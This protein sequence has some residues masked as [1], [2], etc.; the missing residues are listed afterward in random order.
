MKVHNFLCLFVLCNATV[1]VISWTRTN[2]HIVENGTHIEKNGTHLL[3]SMPSGRVEHHRISDFDSSHYSS[4]SHAQPSDAAASRATKRDS[5]ANGWVSSF[6]S[7]GTSYT[8]FLAQWTVPNAPI[9]TQTNIV[10][11]FN[12]FEGKTSDGGSGSDIL[13]PVLQYN[14]GVQGWT[15]AS[16]YGSGSYTESTPVAVKPGDTIT[17]VIS[18]DNGVWSV[19]GYVNGV[20]TT[21]LTIAQ[22]AFN[23]GVAQ[24]TAQW[25][26][27]V[28]NMPDC[29]YYPPNDFLSLTDLVLKDQGAIVSNP[30]FSAPTT[31][32]S[33]GCNAAGYLTTTPVASSTSSILTITWQSGA[34][35]IGS[36]KAIAAAGVDIAQGDIGT[37]SASSALACASACDNNNA[38]VGWVWDSQGKTTCWLKNQITTRTS[39]A[40]RVSGVKQGQKGIDR[41]SHDL[42]GYP[43]TLPSGST[44]S[45]CAAYCNG[46]AACQAWSFNSCGLDCWLKGAVGSTAPNSCRTSGVKGVEYADRPF[47]DLS[48]HDLPAGAD[49]TQCANLCASTSGCTG[50][51]YVLPGPG[52]ETANTC[53]RS[54]KTIFFL[55]QHFAFSF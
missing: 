48:Q 45:T 35:V 20:L 13:Q 50:W 39:N 25:A 33:T 43:I 41:T 32:K 8:Y 16:W 31:P 38:C 30:S 24:N 4:H 19:L 55:N 23:N 6:W 18:L 40:N 54:H 26:L 14:N 3:F 12:S 22:S 11:F 49:T 53:W 52:C 44:A 9:H 21:T 15:L 5:S 36:P 10:F 34:H 2:P 1:G 28:Y 42:P 46:N 29:T 47:G 51:A 37:V 17:G 7:W 27:E